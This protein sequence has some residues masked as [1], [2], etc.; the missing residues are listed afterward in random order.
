M[1]ITFVQLFPGYLV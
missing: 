1:S